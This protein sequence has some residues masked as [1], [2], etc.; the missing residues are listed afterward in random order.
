MYS[1][2]NNSNWAVH[3]ITVHLSLSC[4]KKKY[5]ETLRTRWC[6]D[7]GHH[8]RW[9]SW[10]V[11]HLSGEHVADNIAYG[12]SGWWKW[13]TNK[14]KSGKLQASAPELPQL[15]KTIR[16]RQLHRGGEKK[17][18]GSHKSTETELRCPLRSTELIHCSSVSIFAPPPSAAIK[19]VSLTALSQRNDTKISSFW[20]M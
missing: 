3:H 18:T 6:H 2:I 9:S 7:A 8:G 17:P 16:H 10:A 11:E 4:K 5:I 19:V 13:I 1:L 12:S 14:H 20:G 15:R